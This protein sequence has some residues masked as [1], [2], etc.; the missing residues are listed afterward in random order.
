[1]AATGRR[2][3]ASRK[4]CF[5]AILRV[6]PTKQREFFMTSAIKILLLAAIALTGIGLPVP[7]QAQTTQ[8]LYSTAGGDTTRG[9]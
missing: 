2:E 6:Q 8:G 4:T 9:N 7:V 1:V 3:G 5:V